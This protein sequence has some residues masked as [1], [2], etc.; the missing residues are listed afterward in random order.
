MKILFVSCVLVM[1]FVSQWKMNGWFSWF[2]VKIRFCNL[3]L[4]FILFLACVVILSEILIGSSKYGWKC[5]S[6][7]VCVCVRACLCAMSVYRVGSIG[8]MVVWNAL[9]LFVSVCFMHYLQCRG[10]VL[11]VVDHTLMAYLV[12]FKENYDVF[13]RKEMCS[14]SS[15]AIP[16][17]HGQWYEFWLITNFCPNSP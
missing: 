1:C 14:H 4:I 15:K 3:I 12:L 6:S 17:I 10:F 2:E 7:G 16:G 13:I 5:L 9:P 11:T 8:S